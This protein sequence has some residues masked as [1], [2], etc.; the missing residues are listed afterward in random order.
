ME[1]RR[2]SSSHAED[3]DWSGGEISNPTTDSEYDDV[4]SRRK[5]KYFNSTKRKSGPTRKKPKVLKIEASPRSSKPQELGAV[6]PLHSKSTHDILSPAPVRIA[7]LD[8]YKTVHDTRGMP[9]RKPYDPTLSP[10]R[11]A[12]RAYEVRV[13]AENMVYDRNLPFSFVSDRFGFPRSCYNKR[14]LPQSY[15]IITVG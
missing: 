8:W 13:S 7:L 6:M 2:R 5:S 15:L 4:S 1:K 12:Q 9:W 3:E 11:R 14:K 10:E